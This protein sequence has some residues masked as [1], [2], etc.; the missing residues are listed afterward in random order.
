MIL[1]VAKAFF[2]IIGTMFFVGLIGS[3]AVVILTS[4]ED[5]KELR[6][7]KEAEPRVRMMPE[8]AFGE[9]MPTSRPT[10]AR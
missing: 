1:I 8:S 5:A 2:W 4:I 9:S 6:E 10:Q 7:K 3:G